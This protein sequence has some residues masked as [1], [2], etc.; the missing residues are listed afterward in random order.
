MRIGIYSAQRHRLGD[1]WFRMIKE[2]GF[3]AVDL[4]LTGYESIP[5][6]IPFKEIEPWIMQLK[7]LADEAGIDVFQMHGPWVWPLPDGESTELRIVNTIH[8]VRAAAMLGCE[9]VVVHP[10][11]P[12]GRDHENGN[13][14]GTWD[15][16]LRLVEGVLPTS[17]E[18]GVTL[19]MENLPFQRFS[20]SLTQDV[21]RFVKEVGDERVKICFDTGHSN[22]MDPVSPADTLRSFGDEVRVLHVHDNDGEKDQHLIPYYGKIDWA[23]FGK[24][25][26]EI[27]YDGV[28]SLETGMPGKF[29]AEAAASMY[30][31]LAAVAR[32]V[33][34]S[35]TK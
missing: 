12:F 7:N 4:R 13:E 17:K 14:Q 35:T 25:L 31:A 28:L 2:A 16:N 27:N 23:D 33:A 26:A 15:A 22:K 1:G 10:V 21:Y 20:M 6:E 9:N 18:C 8:T 34:D 5:T 11:M 29:P 30:K 32:N 19:C 24:A 3:D